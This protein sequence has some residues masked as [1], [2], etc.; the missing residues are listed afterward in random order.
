MGYAA[1]PFT[2]FP[3]MT[4]KFHAAGSAD[5]TAFSVNTSTNGDPEGLWRV[6]SASLDEPRGKRIMT[7]VKVPAG[8]YQL[9]RVNAYFSSYR[10]IAEMDV[11]NPPVIEVREGEVSYAGSIH[12]VSRLGT[13]IFGRSIPAGVYLRL[14]D[15]SV[16]DIASMKRADSRLTGLPF[17]N[18]L[19]QQP[20]WA[21]TPAASEKSAAGPAM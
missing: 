13:S 4:A 7:L 19:A 18:A 14:Y 16:N 3:G 21:R 8:R 6:P 15:E 11:V 12:F 17:V 5:T 9:G 10:L 1:Q 20:R 2:G